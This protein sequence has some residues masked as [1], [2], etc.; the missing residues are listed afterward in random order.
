MKLKRIRAGKYESPCGQY[1]IV[2]DPTGTTQG[3]WGYSSWY[4]FRKRGKSPLVVAS[5]HQWSTLWMAKAVLQ[6]I[7]GGAHVQ[8]WSDADAPD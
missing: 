3:G 8:D 6:E 7:L 4:I 2:G 5:E 1:E